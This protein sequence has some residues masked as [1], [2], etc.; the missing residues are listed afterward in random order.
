MIRKDYNTDI[1]PQVREKMKKNLVYLS[2]FSIVMMFAGL[3]SG[4]IVSMGDSFWLKFPM[5]SAFWMSTGIIV[6]SSVFI[7]FGIT[8][9]HRKKNGLSKFFVSLTFVFGLLFVY[10][11]FKGYG[12]L[13]TS[14][15]HFSE[16]I[17]AVDG[18]YGS[19]GE[20]GR[21]YGYYEIKYDGN[22][23]EINGNDYLWKGE[24][25][26]PKQFKELKGFMLQFEK[27]DPK[28]P[29]N[30]S[31]YGNKYTLYYKQQELHLMEGKLA[32]PDG[33]LLEFVE[34]ERLKNLAI[35]I[36]DERGDFFHRGTIGEDFFVYYKGQE[37]DYK[38][39]RWYRKSDGIIL[40]DYL[41]TKPLEAPDTASSY[42]YLITFL[43]LLHIIFTLFYMAKMTVYSLANKWDAH[44]TLSLRLGALF[45]H[46]L[47]ALWI[48]LLLFLLYIH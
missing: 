13:V 17:M 26:S 48:F 22:F 7:Q 33:E 35:N 1:T 32:L 30:V 36:R 21:Y 40:D 3:T 18:R 6:L 39:R 15:S 31:N 28:H 14:G 34:L 20:G 4:Y 25:I 44:N 27:G 11:Q 37:L 2:M 5:P 23:L 29:G 8:F 16:D 41:Q 46:F 12:Q 45:W 24:K 43:H 10:F 9:A 42:L 19:V 38:E 47:G